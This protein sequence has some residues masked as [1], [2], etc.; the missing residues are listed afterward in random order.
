MAT[1]GRLYRAD[2]TSTPPYGR[3]YHAQLQ[4]PANGVTPIGRLYRADLSVPDTGEP[5]PAG[6]LYRVDL[7]VVGIDAPVDRSAM[8]GEIIT[9]TAAGNA[10]SW[11]W[12]QESG[13]TVTI[14]S[15]G[16]VAAFTAPYLFVGA[17]VRLRV[18]GQ[19]GAIWSDWNSIDIAVPAHRYWV[20]RASV[21]V[22]ASPSHGVTPPSGEVATA[23]LFFK[24]PDVSASTKRCF[25]H[26]FGPYPRSINNASSL[27]ADTYTTSF[28]SPRTTAA[29]NGTPQSEM[30]GAFR[31]RPI[32]R[33][34]LGGDF[35]YQDCVFDIQ[36]AKAAGL[37]GFFVD[38][39]GLASGTNYANYET[40]RQAAIDVGGFKIVPMVDAN[41]ATAAATPQ[42][43]AAYVKYF[44]I[45]SSGVSGDPLLP[46]AYTLPSGKF[47]V[48]AFRTEGKPLAWWSDLLFY[49]KNDWGIDA[50]YIGVFVNNSSAGSYASIQVGSGSW[51][52]GA[53]PA[54]INS[55]APVF[56][57]AVRARGEML[58]AAVAAQ[59]V[60]PNAR[61]FD[62]ALNTAA[63]R[64]AWEQAIAANA[65]FVQMVSWSDFSE[66]P[67]APTAANGWVNLDLTAYYIA[68]WKTGQFPAVLADAI[69]L[70]HRNHTTGSSVTGP[71]VTVMTQKVRGATSSVRN[72]VEVLTFLTAPA[73][74]TVTIGGVPYAY[75]AP[76]GMYVATF[77]IAAGAVSAVATRSSV[78]VASVTSPVTVQTSTINDNPGYFR[79]SSI[80]GTAGQFD[81]STL[82]S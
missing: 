35:K 65:D 23:N 3:L 29:F 46:S 34:Q 36:Q 71:Q 80:R 37:D 75:T 30:G 69:Y 24:V 14:A 25:A 49:L 76:A 16:P 2:L 57:A 79:F 39:L 33:A 42:A 41:G 59:D 74:V 31:D 8:P 61:W 11:E 82:Y 9:L 1:V 28:N 68:K 51:G 20:N 66:T 63:L 52:Y 27:A 18:R 72:H 64:A 77:P 38:L 10:T 17:T 13:P 32:F 81:P 73:T 60:R 26:Y 4:V 50:A 19:V 22:P 6:R 12:A 21:W 58:L 48:S 40:L 54:A 78:T 7:V 55:A 44:A 45:G 53:D 47:L 15:N 43:A 67:L 56:A 62:E 70:S 5:T